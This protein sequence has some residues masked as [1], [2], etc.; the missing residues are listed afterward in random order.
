MV[1]TR[2]YY[3]YVVRLSFSNETLFEKGTIES[4]RSFNLKQL[5]NKIKS[6]FTMSGN[7]SKLSQT[8]FYIIHNINTMVWKF[9]A[10]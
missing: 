9:M 8:N 2:S 7:D 3:K 5:P 1:N 6:L 10:L 4:F